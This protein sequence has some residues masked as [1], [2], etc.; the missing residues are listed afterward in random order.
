MTCTWQEKIDGKE[1][2]SVLEKNIQTKTCCEH[3]DGLIPKAA[4]STSVST[5]HQIPQIPLNFQKQPMTAI[6][7]PHVGSPI[8]P[9]A[10]N[11]GQGVWDGCMEK[12]GMARQQGRQPSPTWRS[13][14]W[15]WEL[16]LDMWAQLKDW[17]KG[18]VVGPKRRRGNAVQVQ[19]GAMDGQ[20]DSRPQLRGHL[21]P[22]SQWRKRR[23]QIFQVLAIQLSF[24]SV[25]KGE[26]PSPPVLC[27]CVLCNLPMTDLHLNRVNVR[28]AS[29]CVGEVSEVWGWKYLNYLKL[30]NYHNL[31]IGSLFL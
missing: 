16:G 26:L 27:T 25:M 28:L 30:W 3:W 2:I 20:Q 18:W 1:K 22:V 17:E 10:P 5:F 7:A 19:P 31:N 6:M 29:L 23:A 13:L 21:C 8:A 4:H 15:G 9:R 14:H 24:L 11:S 12:H